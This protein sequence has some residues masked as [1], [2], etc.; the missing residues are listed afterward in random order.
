[1]RRFGVVLAVLMGWLLSGAVA[2]AAPGGQGP[3]P[4]AGQ[5]NTPNPENPAGRILGI[6]PPHGHPDNQA[7]PGGGAGSDLV[8]HRGPVMQTNNVYVIYWT[9]DS[10]QSISF[11]F[12]SD[13]QSLINT[14]FQNVAAASGN[15]DNVYYS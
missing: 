6:V 5:P 15:T 13:Y 7:G 9:G 2:L 8:Y 11:P 10:T 3:N 4:P 1:M 14:Y 12:A